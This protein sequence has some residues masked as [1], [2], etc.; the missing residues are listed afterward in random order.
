[1]CRGD[2]RPRPMAMRVGRAFTERAAAV[3]LAP[4][5]RRHGMQYGS[6]TA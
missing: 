4:G 1:M 5:S 3:T 6:A 2:E